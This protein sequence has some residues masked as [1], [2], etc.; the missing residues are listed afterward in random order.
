M[1][2]PGLHLDDWRATKDTLHLYSQI[3]GKIRLA[4][5]TPCNHWWNAAL[6]VDVRG[7]TTRR[8][9]HRDTTFEITID[10]IDDTLIVRTGDGRTKSFGI[11]SGMP[12]ADF[13]AR[14]HA[15]LSELGVDVNIKEE[16]F[17][18]PTTTPFPHDVEHASWDRDAIARFARILDWSDSVFE[19]F[20][21]WFNGKTSP[22]HLFW[23]SFDLAVTRFSGRPRAP[24]DADPSRK[25]P[26]PTKSSHSD[27]GPATT[28]SATP[29]TTPTPPQNPTAYAS[30]RYPGAPGPSPAPARA[31]D[32][33]LRDGAH[34]PPPQNH[35]ARLLPKRLRSRRPS[36]RLGHQQLR[37]DLVPHPEP[38]TRAA[39]QR[40]R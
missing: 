22:V 35:T 15:T 8:L 27:T 32:P 18:V 5:T 40:R 16:P 39:C 7:L 34:R 24:I 4:T 12:V 11:G 6:Y 36:R 3:L 25:R 26:T 37:I 1:T 10:F 14:I 31:G 23:H 9:H 30:S 29:L 28:T 21:G 33:P 13:D 2:L 38:T 17:G 19:E 20:S